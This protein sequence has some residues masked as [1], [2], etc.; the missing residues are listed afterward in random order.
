MR[1]SGIKFGKRS[2]MNCEM[3][4]FQKHLNENGSINA[5]PTPELLEDIVKEA[6]SC[7]DDFEYFSFNKKKN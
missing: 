7:L 3:T 5:G 2:F 1:E 4:I 6:V